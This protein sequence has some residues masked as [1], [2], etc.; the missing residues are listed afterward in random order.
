[1]FPKAQQAI[2]DETQPKVVIGYA[3][4]ENP[5]EAVLEFGELVAVDLPIE[6]VTRLITSFMLTLIC[7]RSKSGNAPV[8]FSRFR[9]LA[10]DRLWHANASISSKIDQAFAIIVLNNVLLEKN[11]PTR[12]KLQLIFLAKV[13]SLCISGEEDTLLND[14]QL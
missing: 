9:G 13:R 5:V 3:Q 1:M 14:S 10:A 4:T 8:F 7:R 6:K 12:C 2:F 11:T